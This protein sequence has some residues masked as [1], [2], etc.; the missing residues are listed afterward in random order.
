MIQMQTYNDGYARIFHILEEDTLHPGYDLEDVG[1]DLW[2]EEISV[3]D[4]LRSTL[5]A[6]DIDVKRK[7]RTP[8]DPN[9]NAMTVLKIKE[10][11]YKVYNSYYFKDKNGFQKLDITLVEWEG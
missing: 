6:A 8:Y 10:E 11:Y 2:F 3:S 9:I 1:Y 4:R 5:N 7:I